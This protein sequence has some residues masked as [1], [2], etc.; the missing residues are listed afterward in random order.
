MAASSSTAV[1]AP[2]PG[3]PTA[4]DNRLIE[5]IFACLSP[6]L[7][8][9]WRKAWVVVTS[10]ASAPSAKF[11]FSTTRRDSDGEEL[12]PCSAQAITRSITGLNDRL[13]PPQRAWS[14]A[15]LTIDSEGEYELT[16]DYLK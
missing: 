11:Y 3:V 4:L 9:D 12:V 15:T 16:Y 7:P 5:R 13:P 2:A 10:G 14:K 6:G 8:Q 1:A